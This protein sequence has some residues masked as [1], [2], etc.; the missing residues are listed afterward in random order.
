MKTQILQ[1]LQN[2]LGQLNAAIPVISRAQLDITDAINELLKLHDSELVDAAKAAKDGQ[3][4]KPDG[5][6]SENS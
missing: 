4:V 5:A 6:E 3:T 1:A 2:R